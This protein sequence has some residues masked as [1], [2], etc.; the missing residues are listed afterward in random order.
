[1]LFVVPACSSSANSTHSAHKSGVPICFSCAN[2]TYSTHKNGVPPCFYC[3]NV[4][5]PA[6]KNGVPLASP[7]QVQAI[8]LTRVV[9]PPA[10]LLIQ[11]I[12][13]STKCK[14]FCSQERWRVVRSVHRAHSPYTAHLYTHAMLHATGRSR[15]STRVHRRQCLFISD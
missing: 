9:C 6:H 1:M 2:V 14:P 8:L 4:T 3:A 7:V 5:H 15:A 10:F 11:P 13:P 12:L